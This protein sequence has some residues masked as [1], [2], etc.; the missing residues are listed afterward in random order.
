MKPSPWIA[1]SPPEMAA[2]GSTEMT[3]GF[4]CALS[5]GTIAESMELV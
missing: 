5:L 2:R 3:R 1:I 4:A